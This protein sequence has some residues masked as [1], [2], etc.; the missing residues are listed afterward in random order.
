L[1]ARNNIFLCVL[2]GSISIWLW[3]MMFRPRHSSDK[4]AR[5]P[6]YIAGFRKNWTSGG[7]G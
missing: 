3:F 1:K 7:L 2:R 5:R 4:N 6:L